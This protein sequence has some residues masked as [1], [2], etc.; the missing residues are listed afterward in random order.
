VSSAAEPED[1]PQV[2]VVGAG[3]TGLLLAAELERRDV[4]CELI[5]VLDAPRHLEGLTG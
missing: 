5:D 2:L 4:S 3:P 1:N